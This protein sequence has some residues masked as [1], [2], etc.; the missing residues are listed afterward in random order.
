[1]LEHAAQE[2]GNGGGALGAWPPRGQI[3]E[4]VVGAEWSKVGCDL[5]HNQAK[6]GQGPKTKIEAHM[7]LYIFH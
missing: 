2:V 5:G 4:H 6:F 1:V 7:M 3:V